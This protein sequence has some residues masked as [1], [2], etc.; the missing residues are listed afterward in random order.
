MRFS[1]V[2]FIKKNDENNL[3]MELLTTGLNS[4]ASAQ[5]FLDKTLTSFT[6][7]LPEK[8]NL[9]GQWEVTIS[10]R[11]D[12]LMYQNVTEGIFG[13]Y[14]KKHSKSSEFYYLEPGFYPSDTI[15]VETMNNFPQQR[16]SHS[17]SCITLKLSRRM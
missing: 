1:V 11:S 14:D 4:N 6:T 10:E 16:H 9:E 2:N 12:P 15:I 3:T 17:Q 13:F 5:L 7:F 8:T